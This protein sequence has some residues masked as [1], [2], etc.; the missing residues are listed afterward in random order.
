MNKEDESRLG[1][2]KHFLNTNPDMAL[3]QL[4]ILVQN[5]VKMQNPTDREIEDIF[6]SGGTKKNGKIH[7]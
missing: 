2:Y 5:A 1:L 4:E 6:G 3:R 7:R